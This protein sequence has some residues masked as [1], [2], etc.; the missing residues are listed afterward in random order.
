LNG[1]EIITGGS[2][3]IPIDISVLATTMSTIKNRY[4]EYKAHLEP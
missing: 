2:I 1:N 4:E 3:I